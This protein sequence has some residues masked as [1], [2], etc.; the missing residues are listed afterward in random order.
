MDRCPVRSKDRD[1]GSE[2]SDLLP[3]K[4]LCTDLVQKS[5]AEGPSV[6]LQA[7]DPSRKRSSRRAEASYTPRPAVGSRA[8][9]VGGP[10]RYSMAVVR[11]CDESPACE[12]F[13]YR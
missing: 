6:R 8:V 10:R 1:R 9:S 13:G 11:W 2:P 12:A 3:R 7:I 5:S 4:L